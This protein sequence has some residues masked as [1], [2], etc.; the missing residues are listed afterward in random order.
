M[1][2][3]R[4][5][6]PWTTENRVPWL[7]WRPAIA[8]WISLLLR[9]SFHPLQHDHDQCM[10]VKSLPSRSCEP[11]RWQG[12]QKHFM[13]EVW[14]C[15]AEVKLWQAV[16]QGFSC[17]HSAQQTVRQIRHRLGNPTIKTWPPPRRSPVVQCSYGQRTN[18]P[19]S[20]RVQNPIATQCYRSTSPDSSRSWPLEAVA[21]G[22]C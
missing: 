16:V 14:L 10:Q 7:P 21:I 5:R 8:G 20:P 11:S 9:P 1:F 3:G 6:R 18:R 4:V 2:P 22:P 15:V 12:L 17:T 19:W 13:S